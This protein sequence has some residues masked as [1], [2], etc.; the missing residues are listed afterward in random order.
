M[1]CDFNGGD[2]EDG[3]TP[4]GS[5][6]YRRF[7]GTYRLNHQGGKNKR[8]RKVSSNWQLK[9][10]SPFVASNDVGI[11]WRYSNSPAHE[12]LS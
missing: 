3:V 1:I 12:K 10:G 11:W 6:R 2:Y 5:C 4:C 7:G 9:K 8:A